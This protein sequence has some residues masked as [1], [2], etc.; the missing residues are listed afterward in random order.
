[1]TKK[2]LVPILL[3][4]GLALLLVLLPQKKSYDE[5][6]PKELLQQVCASSRFISP[7][8]VADRII[9]KD[10]SLVLIDVRNTDEYSAY[11]LPG[12]LN[13]PLS[14]LLKPEQTDLL[15]QDGID[16]IFYSNSDIQADKAWILCKR[17][18]L[19]NIFVLKGGLNAWFST[20]FL[21]EPLPE[22]ES[23]AEIELYQFRSGVR[24]Y[25][26]GGTITTPANTQAEK[27][28]VTPKVKKAAAEGGC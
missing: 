10:P 6:Q 24:Q 23:A 9:K 7:D 14:D 25:F 28:T 1:M 22:T 20:F 5:M 4:L 8:I 12:A 27:I 16:F 15:T 13:I 18:G 2:Y 3:L 11:S 21:S 17:K 26:T 19:Q